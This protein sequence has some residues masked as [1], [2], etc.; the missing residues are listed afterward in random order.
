MLSYSLV[1][2]SC[3]EIYEGQVLGGASRCRSEMNVTEICTGGVTLHPC[4]MGLLGDCVV[5]TEDNCTFHKGVWHPELVLCS[6]LGTDCFNHICEFA[7]IG[8][9][10]GEIPSQG[11][12]FLSA[13]FLYDGIITLLIIGLFKLYNSWKVERRIG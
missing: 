1:H 7:W 4:C 2:F 13:L 9:T 8:K 12:R 6:E 3:T 10:I 11:L 5:T